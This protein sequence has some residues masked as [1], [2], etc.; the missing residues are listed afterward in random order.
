MVPERKLFWSSRLVRLAK[1][2]ISDGS[3]PSR[4]FVPKR[5]LL[6]V[7]TF[8][9]V[10][11]IVEVKKLPSKSSISTNGYEGVSM[12]ASVSRPF[13]QGKYQCFYNSPNDK[14]SPISSGITPVNEH[15]AIF[16]TAEMKSTAQVSILVSSD[17]I[18]LLYE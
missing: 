1:R 8:P 17:Y 11:G 16:R 13:L 5:M 6:K 12:R 3:G 4:T 14:K 2:P 10:V 9:I 18:F 15:V 7:V